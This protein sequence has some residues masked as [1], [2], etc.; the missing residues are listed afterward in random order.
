MRLI[1]NLKERER[2]REQGFFKELR[3]REQG[4]FKELREREDEYDGHVTDLTSSRKSV[5]IIDMRDYI[6]GNQILEFEKV[7][8]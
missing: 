1:V 7:P 2:E 8:R 3:E 5:F 6:A 4:F